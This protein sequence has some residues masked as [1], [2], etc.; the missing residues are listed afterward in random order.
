[1]QKEKKTHLHVFS[2]VDSK[3]LPDI[4]CQDR[5]SDSNVCFL[6]KSDVVRMVFANEFI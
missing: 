3:W 5:F 6:A 1:M 4:D 2:M